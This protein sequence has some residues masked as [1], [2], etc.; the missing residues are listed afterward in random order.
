[1][2]TAPGAR[3]PQEPT[4]PAAPPRAVPGR[5]ERVVEP[6][7]VLLVAMAVGLA[8]VLLVT[9]RLAPTEYREVRDGFGY[10]VEAVTP[11]RWDVTIHLLA[12]AL[13]LF[14]TVVATGPF[15]ALMRGEAR[16]DRETAL[17]LLGIVVAGVALVFS[18]RDLFELATLG[19]YV[20]VVVVGIRHRSLE[21]N[22][23]AR[24][25]YREA[26][27]P[28]KSFFLLSALVAFGEV[29]YQLDFPGAGLLI[30]VFLVWWPLLLLRWVAYRRSLTTVRYPKMLA[31]PQR[32]RALDLL[33]RDPRAFLREEWRAA[34]AG[35]YLGS[36]GDQWLFS[37]RE[38]SV[39]VL[40]PPR[41][42][43][44]AAVV[45]PTIL[46][47]D[48]PLLSTSTKTDVLATTLA[49][50]AGIGRCWLF[51]PTGSV[52]GHD[53]VPRLKWSPTWGCADWDRARAIAHAMVGAAAPARGVTSE[54]HWTERAGTLL[55]GLLHA[56]DLAGQ[57]MG[58]LA[59]WVAE[60]DLQTPRDIVAAD[61]RAAR[62]ARGTLDG[63][64]VTEHRERS[65]IWSTTAGV[66][67]AYQSDRALAM[68]ELAAGEE[69][70]DADAFVR[71]RDTVYVAASS[72]QQR[73]TAPIVVAFIEGIRRATFR[74][75]GTLDAPVL[76]VLDEAKNIAPIHDLPSLVS[77]AGGQ[78]LTVVA[79]FQDLSQAE[80]RWGAE[81]KGFL[82]LFNTT[83]IFRG[84]REKDTLELISALFGEHEVFTR[85]VAEPQIGFW[86][87]IAY[88]S[89]NA[90]PPP[91]TLT[92][93]TRKERRVPL[94]AVA[95]G[96]PGYAVCLAGPARPEWLR[97]TPWYADGVWRAVAEGRGGATVP[98]Y[99]RMASAGETAASR[100]NAR[101]PAP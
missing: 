86:Q 97:L 54:G 65:G 41:S 7:R 50:R 3:H 101:V 96:D 39:L 89:A 49:T 16:S 95:Q 66:V 93:A 35:A 85:S 100:P 56:A 32:K 68:T 67:S 5:W 61:P 82:S 92:T 72:E 28:W 27:L 15:L 94:E 98:P 38:H 75:A 10:E 60:H 78:G 8:V 90:M 73:V 18:V 45:V 74:A 37:D 29:L 34:G 25:W 57:G 88:A 46:A 4:R 6:Y 43:K 9:V 2:T 83:L 51:D 55:A 20:V 19:V 31:T 21:G 71:G 44:T 33:A 58:V 11:E 64:A 62:A 87:R 24:W 36:G 48:G 59:Q 23:L 47:S 79:V 42:G 22:S 30:A 26:P 17:T 81:A 53:D 12:L 91:T 14:V 52:S 69:R 76:L 99:W 40:G 84:I 13:A 80:Q 77:E 1:M 70:F 63:I